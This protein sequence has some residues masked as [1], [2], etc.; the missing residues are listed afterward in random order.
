MPKLDKASLWSLEQY[1]EQRPA[2][3]AEVIEHKKQR[4][5]AVGAHATFYFEDYLTMKYQV[6]EMLRVERI[7]EAQEIRSELEAY[8]PLIPDGR[9]LK[10][11]FM[12]EYPDAE[13]RRLALGKLGGIE[14]TLW[15]Q[16]EG[17]S[18][19]AAIAN[20]DMERSREDKASAVHFLRF[21]LTPE[22]VA[23][24]K[25]GAGLS[26][27]IAHEHYNQQAD[28]VPGKIRQSLIDDLA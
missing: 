16:A 18:R 28:P 9:N 10:A 23:A 20:E 8:N 3:R 7:F 26:I 19:I 6:Q 22:M 13:E 12:I 25:V 27:G 21:E 17:Q 14:D 2:F 4:R 15:L 1:A 11:T 24:L 5:I